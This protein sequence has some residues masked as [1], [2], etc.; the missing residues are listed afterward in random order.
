MYAMAKDF[1]FMTVQYGRNKLSAKTVPGNQPVFAP[2]CKG[3]E[4][5]GNLHAALIG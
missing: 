2:A 3:E 4:T 5:A 1:I